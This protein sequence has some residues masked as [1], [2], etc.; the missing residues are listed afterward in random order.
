MKSQSPY[1]LLYLKRLQVANRGFLD[2]VRGLSVASRAREAKDATCI[3]EISQDVG[4]ESSRRRLPE[5]VRAE[6]LQH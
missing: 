5:T 2:Y 1:E 6:E 4:W 3:P